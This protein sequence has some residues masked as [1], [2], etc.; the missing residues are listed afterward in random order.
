MRWSSST[1]RQAKPAYSGGTFK[2]RR[3]YYAAP[4]LY[5][6]EKIADPR[7]RVHAIRV[8]KSQWRDD[9]KSAYNDTSHGD[10][11][12]AVEWMQRLYQAKAELPQQPEDP[13]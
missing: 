13:E 5:Q 11:K 9:P 4:E 2:T 7:E 1:T 12:N 8:L 10:H 6:I 3:P